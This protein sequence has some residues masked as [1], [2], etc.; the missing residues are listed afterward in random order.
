MLFSGTPISVKEGAV[1]LMVKA[2]LGLNLSF[3][4]THRVMVARPDVSLSPTFL[5][6]EMELLVI[7]QI[8]S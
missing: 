6:G 1:W 3:L 5:V 8:T 7:T 4:L 2:D